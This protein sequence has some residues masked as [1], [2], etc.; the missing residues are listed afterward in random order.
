MTTHS[1]FENVT[2]IITEDDDGHAELIQDLLIDQDEDNA[3]GHS[4][5]ECCPQDFAIGH[6]IGY[7][8]GYGIDHGVI[9]LRFPPG[10]KPAIL[11]RP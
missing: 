8:I 7:G 5:S 11:F 2:I 6:G 4:R 3:C 10:S 9:M 1:R